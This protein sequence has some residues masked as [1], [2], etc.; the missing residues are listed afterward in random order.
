MTEPCDL[1]AVEARRLI[2]R[3]KLSD[4]E[5]DDEVKPTS[6][7]SALTTIVKD[8]QE[9][10]ILRHNMPF[11][12]PGMGEFGTFFIGYARSPEPIEQML[13]NMFVGRP[14]GNYDRLLDYSTAVTGCLFFV[15]PADMLETLAER[16]P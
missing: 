13:E 10:K 9:V 3:K 4:I 7:H 2:G 1:S 6:A 12:R 16:H 15:P 8:G 14:P 11:G 5:L